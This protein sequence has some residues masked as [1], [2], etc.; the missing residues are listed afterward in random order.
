MNRRSAIVL[1]LAALV[2]AGGRVAAQQSVD[3]II[4]KNLQAKGG[5]EKI[6]AV[7]SIRQTSHLTAAMPSG[8]PLEG[9]LVMYSRRPNL[10]RQEVNFATGQTMITAF[11]GQTA[12]SLNPL[13]GQSTPTALSG[14]QADAAKE[15]ADFDGPFV[16]YKAKGYTVELIG[17]EPAGDRKVYHLKVTSKDQRIQH[18]YVDTVTSLESR[19]V[20]EL[21]TP[22]GKWEMEQQLS[23]FRDVEGLKVPF[24]VKTLMNGAEQA[25]LKVEKVEFNAKFDDSV[26]KMPKTN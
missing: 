23:D 12:W 26:F 19:V 4:A 14:P 10:S 17:T 22:M 15:Q 20:S 16:D 13:T 7:Q 24:L 6:K 1:I 18:V 2:F 9:T 8:P 11:D 3:D 21:Q 5:L 25:T